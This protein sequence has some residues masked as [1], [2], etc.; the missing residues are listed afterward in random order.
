MPE[1]APLNEN[2]LAALCLLCVLAGA[3]ITAMFFVARRLD[4]GVHTYAQRAERQF[5]I[6]D[7]VRA[8]LFAGL[9][10]MIVLPVTG[11]IGERT[12]EARIADAAMSDHRIERMLARARCKE[13]DAP[14]EKLVGPIATQAD[15][16]APT[17]ECA[18][19]T[20]DLGVIPRVRYA[21]AEV[22]K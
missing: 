22:G 1:I 9:I 20:A 11:W 10:V 16:K 17:V 15:G 21:A 13:P 8:C 5:A 19:V 6:S 14:L 7:H 12:D 18:Y 2:A 4:R 3:V